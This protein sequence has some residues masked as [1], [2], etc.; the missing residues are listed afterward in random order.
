MSDPYPKAT[1]TPEYLYVHPGVIAKLEADLARAVEA[2]DTA[3]GERAH[4][5]ADLAR[6]T[7]ERDAAMSVAEEW[8]AMAVKFTKA[9]AQEASDE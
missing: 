7:E 3:Q 6:V 1:P 8:Q 2:R 4:M 9:L 5:K